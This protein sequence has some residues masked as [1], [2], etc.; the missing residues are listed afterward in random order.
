MILYKSLT[1]ILRSFSNLGIEKITSFIKGL[2][3]GTT[4]SST[5]SFSVNFSCS[6]NLN[7]G[8]KVRN[9]S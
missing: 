7:C 1:S 4:K 8:S 2:G 9:N 6:T 3:K 5:F